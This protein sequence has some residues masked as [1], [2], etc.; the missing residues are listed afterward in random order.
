MTRERRLAIQMWKDIRDML[1]HNDV[2]TSRDIVKYKQTFCVSHGLYWT[3]NCWFCKY[4]PSCGECMLG[5]CK[6][7][8]D[9]YI[10]K[11]S[12]LRHD[13]RVKACNNIIRALGGEA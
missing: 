11:N 9:Y 5:S 8:G 6:S 3:N 10:V 2:V 7:G 4:I 12:W 13:I 1:M